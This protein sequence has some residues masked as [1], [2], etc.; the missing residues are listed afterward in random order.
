LKTDSESLLMPD[1][2]REFERD[3]KSQKSELYLN[4]ISTLRGTFYWS[5]AISVGIITKCAI[6]GWGQFIASK[7]VHPGSRHSRSTDTL[8]AFKCIFKILGGVEVLIIIVNRQFMGRSN[9]ARVT[10]SAPY[11]VQCSF[12]G[13]S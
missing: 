5:V 10:T 11:N 2:G 3:E 7:I 12:S 8:D 6:F 9:M 4:W 13:N 1:A